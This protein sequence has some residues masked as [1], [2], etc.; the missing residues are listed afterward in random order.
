MR[1]S[2]GSEDSEKTGESTRYAEDHSSSVNPFVS[3]VQSLSDDS[4][5][6]DHM[7]QDLLPNSNSPGIEEYLNSPGHVGDM[8]IGEFDGFPNDLWTSSDAMSMSPLSQSARVY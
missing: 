8:A 5:T 4:I 6:L 2:P 3:P 7:L 1:R